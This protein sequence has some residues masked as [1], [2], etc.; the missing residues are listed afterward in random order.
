VST[1]EKRPYLEGSQPRGADISG[2]IEYSQ[3]D[4]L[5]K[6]VNLQ[7]I[8][9]SIRTLSEFVSKDRWDK[10]MTILDNRTDTV[11][12]VFENPSNPSNVWAVLRTLDSF[13]IQFADIVSNSSSNAN[14]IRLRE[15]KAA[16]G[17]QKWMTVHQFVNISDCIQRLKGEGYIILATD[18][19]EKS[20]SIRDFDFTINSVNLSALEDGAGAVK[21]EKYA[22]IMG[23]E[24]D[25]VSREAKS[26][27][28]Y[29][30]HIPMI[31]FAESFNLSVASAIICAMI[32]SKGLI[33]PNLSD[34]IKMRIL[35]VWISRTVRESLAILRS[36]GLPFGGQRV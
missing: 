34:E 6:R 4:P 10:M 8:I 16:L 1:S 22:I 24:K 18:L 29:L 3:D 9:Q 26:Q 12:F 32:S 7:N 30:I 28:D 25:G 2:S 17:S 13:G 15:M 19:H 21:R 11:R 36:K 20:I 14:S 31:G 5:W 23:N 33:R 27:A 35:F